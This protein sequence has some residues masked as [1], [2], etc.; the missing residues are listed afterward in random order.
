MRVARVRRQDVDEALG[1]LL[2][3]GSVERGL[4]VIC[5]ARESH[6]IVFRTALRGDSDYAP[7][8]II[9]GGDCR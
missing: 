4:K 7:S 8:R 5:A 2:E 6:S 3:A 1:R 9:I